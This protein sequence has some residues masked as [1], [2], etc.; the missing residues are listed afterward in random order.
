MGTYIG[1]VQIGTT[2]VPVA[3]SIFG[4]CSTAANVATKQV[5]CEDFDKLCK[6]IT[7]L[8]KNR[9]PY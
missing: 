2:T 7:N 5:T 8:A 1:K 4:I 6:P 9:L 3:S